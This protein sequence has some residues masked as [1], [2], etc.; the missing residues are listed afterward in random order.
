[1]RKE[2]LPAPRV[3]VTKP[4][5]RVDKHS[6]L[7]AK[8]DG[9]VELL[10]RNQAVPEGIRTAQDASNTT[11]RPQRCG[12]ALAASPLYQLSLQAGNQPRMPL[13]TPN[14]ISSEDRNLL[15]KGHTTGFPIK[16]AFCQ[17]TAEAK[18]D[19][20]A[21]NDASP[22]HPPNAGV[23]VQGSFG[24]MTL[25]ARNSLRG[26]SMADKSN[27]ADQYPTPTPSVADIPP[28][29]QEELWEILNFYRDTM[30]HFSPIVV[31]GSEVTV[32]HMANERPYTWL[33]LR[34]ICTK[35]LARQLA[36]GEEINRLIAQKLIIEGERSL[37]MLC[38]LVLHVNWGQFSCVKANLSPPINLAI[39]LA[40][41]LGLTKPA[42][43]TSPAVM[44]NWT[45]AGC[46]KPP[47]ALVIRKRTMEERRVVLGLFYVS[48]VCANFFQRNEPMRF[49]PYLEEC[50]NLIADSNDQPTD[51][52]LAALIRVQLIA[53]S[54]QSEGWNQTY[55]LSSGGS[56]LPR[57]HYTQMHKMQLDDMKRTIPADIKDN[58]VLRFHIIATE[59]CLYEHYLIPPQSTLSPLEQAR[60]VDGLWSCFNT[61]RAFF[62]I[63]LASNTI[64]LTDYLYLSISLYTHMGHALVALFR[65]S[66]FESEHVP[67]NRQ[68]IISQVDL[69]TVVKQWIDLFETSPRAAKIDITGACGQDSQWDYSKKI[70]LNTISKW[71]ET[72][73]RPSIMG[74][75][76]SQETTEAPVASAEDKAMSTEQFDASMP[77]LGDLCDIDFNFESEAWMRDM[78]SSGFDF[79][80]F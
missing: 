52:L 30:F 56:Q 6:A 46:P 80:T 18:H 26:S 2:C 29:T 61:V 50:L 69:G 42:P 31:I 78:F 43:Q 7:E 24:H 39:G 4:K 77:D 68:Y 67:W 76:V 12:P 75:E 71:W 72:K 21:S 22:L 58:S 62:D 57:S 10:K 45:Q 44:M 8:V 54:L 79:R 27:D 28:E 36:F 14:S 47:H 25:E 55:S 73:V 74:E 19:L 37:D 40:G 41:D 65:L 53:N 63:S 48:S 11:E 16:S 49:T 60:H 17:L 20:S 5:A 23:Q 70:L 15:A 51:K 34:M 3:R 64:P 1:M 33:V 38:A 13:S 59:L 32:E 9:I 35:K 66:T